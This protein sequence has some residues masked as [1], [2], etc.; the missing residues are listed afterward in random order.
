MKEPYMIYQRDVF[1]QSPSG[2][3]AAMQMRERLINAGMFASMHETTKAIVITRKPVE[4]MGEWEDGD[5]D[6]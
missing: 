1:N 6:G 2:Y 3:K 4:I 5:G